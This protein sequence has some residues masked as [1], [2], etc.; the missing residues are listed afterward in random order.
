VSSGQSPSAIAC[1]A[2]SQ[3]V[4]PRSCEGISML[5][6]LGQKAEGCRSS[7]TS[8][9]SKFVH[10]RECE[11]LYCADCFEWRHTK[12]S[13]ARHK[14]T[15]KME[16]ACEDCLF[17][18]A[19][20]RCSACEMFLCSACTILI[21][22]AGTMRSHESNGRFEHFLPRSTSG[23][24]EQGDCIPLVLGH[25]FLRPS[26]RLISPKEKFVWEHP[27]TCLTHS[28]GDH[29]SPMSHTILQ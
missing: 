3:R 28:H 29:V 1:N 10:C 6:V 13:F 20:L 21:H 22:K 8:G 18:V 7:C 26:P 19:V 24:G 23:L 14:D 9:S 25:T 15:Y 16:H 2:Q 5:Q 17:T 27:K 4:S 11:L 12:G